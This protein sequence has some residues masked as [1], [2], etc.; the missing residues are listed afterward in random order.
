MEATIGTVLNQMNLNGSLPTRMPPSSSQ[1]SLAKVMPPAL[2]DLKMQYPTIRDFMVAH[3]PERQLEI[4]QFPEKCF[5]GNSPSLAM[6]NECYGKGAAEGWL[7]P[8]IV[9]ACLFCGLTEQPGI[10]QLEKLV[11]IIV[12]S[13]GYLTVD[14]M[15]LFFFRF[16]SSSYLHFFNTFD[17]F[18]IIRS[19][20]FFLRER[21]YVYHERDER[22]KDYKIEIM[23]KN[24]FRPLTKSP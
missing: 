23:R 2:M 8:E 21:D 22:L 14:E 13:F 6:L 18:I 5:F 15:Q 20:R 7:V 1:N 10:S 19:L 11:R 17:P 24:A 12:T 3:N 16:C 9:D 4:C